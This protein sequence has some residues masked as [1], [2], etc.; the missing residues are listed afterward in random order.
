VKKR[1]NGTVNGPRQI[2]DFMRPSRLS[3][4][5]PTVKIKRSNEQSCGFLSRV[6]N[7]K[8]NCGR[9]NGTQIKRLDNEPSRCP[10]NYAHFYLDTL[11]V[12]KCD[13]VQERKK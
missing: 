5:E 11:V 7:L 2:P 4:D 3:H 6:S 8:F 12:R 1:N 10:F 13:A 9:E